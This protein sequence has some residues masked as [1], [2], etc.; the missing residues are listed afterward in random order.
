MAR[1]KDLFFFFITLGCLCFNHK[2]KGGI[3]FEKQTR[4]CMDDEYATDSICFFYRLQ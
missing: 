4:I 2:F 3:Y 1:G